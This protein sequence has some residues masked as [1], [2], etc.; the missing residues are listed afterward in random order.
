[1]T[2]SEVRNV[3]KSMRK[4]NRR[5]IVLPAE[6]DVNGRRILCTAYD[7]SLGGVRL[8][9]DMAIAENSRVIV[10]L[11][12]KLSQAANVIWSAEGYVGLNFKENPNTVKAEMGILAANLN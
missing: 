9:V 4:H 10:K 5:A 2:K 1:M 6:I 8:K 7:V 3:L 11:R 12:D